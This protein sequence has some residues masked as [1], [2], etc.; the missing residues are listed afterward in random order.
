MDVIVW[1]QLFTLFCVLVCLFKLAHPL[2]F[3]NLV[4]DKLTDENL[5]LRLIIGELIS[6]RNM[7]YALKF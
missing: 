4:R 6:H 7:N 2:V 3:F 5:D 1:N